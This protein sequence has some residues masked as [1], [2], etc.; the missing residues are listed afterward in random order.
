MKKFYLI[1]ALIVVPGAGAW[2]FNG[3]LP[4]FNPP[5]KAPAN[6]FSF[7]KLHMAE[8]WEISYYAPPSLGVESPRQLSPG[9]DGW[10]FAATYSDKI[11]AMRDSDGDGV[12]DEVRTVLSDLKTPR[13]VLFWDGDLYAGAIDG[14]YRAADVMAQMAG[15]GPISATLHIGGFIDSKWHSDRKSVV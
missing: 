4:S 11:Y 6:E 5:R 15:G 1:A 14:I 13:G 9:E 7:G 8:G 10:I 12:A 3:L 2:F